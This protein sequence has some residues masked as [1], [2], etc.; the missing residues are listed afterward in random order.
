MT[1]VY[2]ERISVA[3]ISS[4]AAVNALR[5][6]SVVTGSSV[7]TAISAFLSDAHHDRAEGID[8]RRR[9][10]R[11]PR[12]GGGLDDPRRSG[13]LGARAEVL[14]PEDPRRALAAA[15]DDRALLAGHVAVA[16][17]VVGLGLGAAE[18]AEPGR[19]HSDHFD[20][21]ARVGVTEPLVVCLVEALRQGCL[22]IIVAGLGGTAQWDGERVLLSH[23]ADVQRMLD[24]AVLAPDALL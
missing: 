16:P 14:A 9:G 13:D 10:G 6:I 8:A 12:G 17:G 24:A 1:G 11:G 23:V 20:R 3:F 21:C 19:A 5:M 15:E 2:A 18:V 4:A 22:E 7:R